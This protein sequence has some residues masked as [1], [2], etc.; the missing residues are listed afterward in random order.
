M[1]RY[2]SF[3]LIGGVTA[4]L[5]FGW[6]PWCKPEF[7]R[8]DEDRDLPEHEDACGEEGGPC[9]E[10]REPPSRGRPARRPNGSG[11]PRLVQ[12]TA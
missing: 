8:R 12:V 4:M 5:F 7:L 3:A 9:L 2:E 11:R 10:H 6:R 1:G